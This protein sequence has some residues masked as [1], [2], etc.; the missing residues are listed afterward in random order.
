M[1]DSQSKC[2]PAGALGHSQNGTE[3]AP[4]S[5][6]RKRETASVFAEGASGNDP[7]P[8]KE[9]PIKAEGLAES[10]APPQ[11]TLRK[12]CALCPLGGKGHLRDPGS[13]LQWPGG[14]GSIPLGSKQE[15]WQETNPSTQTLDR[16]CKSGLRLM[17][18]ILS[19]SART[20]QAAAP[21]RVSL[22]PKVACG[23][24]SSQH[25]SQPGRRQPL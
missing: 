6:L 1:T 12:D 10:S 23:R 7:S 18:P 22:I 9:N 14:L 17:K 5:L 2:R 8:G 11:A 15:P 25:F 21:G 24:L 19:H 16:T 20:W 4:P 3:L 13:L